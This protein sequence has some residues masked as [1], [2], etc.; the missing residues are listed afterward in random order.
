MGKVY[1][2]AIGKESNPEQYLNYVLPEYWQAVRANN[3]YQWKQAGLPLPIYCNYD[4]GIFLI[5]F[6]SLPIV[7]SIA[8]IQPSQKIYFLHSEDTKPKCDEITDRITEMLEILLPL[9]NR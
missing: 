7:L 3:T 6:S 1:Y 8:E 5:G 9:C 4:V 2:K